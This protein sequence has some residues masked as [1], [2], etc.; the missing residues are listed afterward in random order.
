[1]PKKII[2]VFSCALILIQLCL[3][4]VYAVSDPLEVPN[5]KIG[6][7]ILFP[8]EVDSAADLIN[9]SHGDWG[10]VTIPIQ[11]GDRDIEKWQQFMDECKKRHVIP[12]IRLATQGDYFNT[13]VW[14][15][16]T[17]TDIVDFANF[18]DSL[19]WPTKNRYV[20]IFNE[21]NRGDEW[22]G[23]PN[24][25]EY[26]HILSLASQTFKS[27]SPDFFIISAGLDNAA[28]NTSI[29]MNQYTFLRQMDASIPGIFTQI[30]GLGSHSYPNPAFSSPPDSN[31]NMSISS[32]TYE[33]Q[34]VTQLSQKTL[35]V[36]ITETG[37]TRSPL[38]DDTIIAYYKTAFESIWNDPGLVAV[39]PFLLTA[40]GGQFANFSLFDV[41]NQQ[42]PEYKV[43]FSLPKVLGRPLPGPEVLGTHIVI[44]EPRPTANFTD[45]NGTKDKSASAAL[46]SHTLAHFFKWLLRVE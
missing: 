20:I 13:A 17:D 31:T 16:P 28:A 38:S 39:T 5:N 14:R 11:A 37:W 42:T 4:K 30:D 23:T 6:V 32:F 9:S 27:R 24:P 22:D 46:N 41:H 33:R 19:N 44:A 45:S 21:V 1:M 7:H 36:F 18:L 26:A 43:L 10:Y 29:S 15:K 34:L 25:D 35:P 2:T 12:L 3:T 40:N 8:S